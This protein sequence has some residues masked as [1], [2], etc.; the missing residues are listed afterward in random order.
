MTC[1]VDL[2]AA[3]S[4]RVTALAAARDA[5]AAGRTDDAFTLY[6]LTLERDGSDLDALLG[7]AVCHARRREWGEA[8]IPLR[9]LCGRLP[10]YATARAY[11][12]AAR[13]E[14][15]E[16]DEGRAD[17]DA[18]VALDSADLVARLKRAEVSLRLGLL[19]AA[20]ADLRVAAR[21]PAPDDTLRDYTRALLADVRKQGRQSIARAPFSPAA[22]AR[23]VAR[24]VGSR[25]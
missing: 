6:R 14:L 1:D 16:V 9:E 17:L 13:F 7:L 23:G 15:G 20:E 10:E 4:D 2:A 18:A 19:P 11:L 21:L 5:L 24:L 12:G 22:L 3:A 25:S 8:L